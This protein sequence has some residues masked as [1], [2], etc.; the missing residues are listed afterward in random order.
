MFTDESLKKGSISG[1]AS[2]S[3][4]SAPDVPIALHLGSSDGRTGF[5]VPT[6]QK[7]RKNSYSLLW[8]VIFVGICCGF[9]NILIIISMFI[10]MVIN[11]YERGY[12][13]AHG[14]ITGLKLVNG[15]NCFGVMTYIIPFC[16]LYPNSFT[17]NADDF[18]G[19]LHVGPYFFLCGVGKYLK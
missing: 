15:H 7:A 1:G 17:Q 19:L 5:F 9:L 11:G 6:M 3:R 13:S 12:H 10:S 16:G 2:F 14:I 8:M 4:L 18:L